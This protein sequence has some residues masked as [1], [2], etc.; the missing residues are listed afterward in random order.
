[1]LRQVHDV[2]SFA[3]VRDY[4]HRHALPPHAGEVRATDTQATATGGEAAPSEH[5]DI[6]E[7]RLARVRS[8]GG[9]FDLVEAGTALTEHLFD[10][11]ATHGVVPIT[12]VRKRPE[13]IPVRHA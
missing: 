6:L 3:V 12:R 7:Q 13:R 5:F 4:A 8:L 11:T 2:S 10:P 9:P 1:M